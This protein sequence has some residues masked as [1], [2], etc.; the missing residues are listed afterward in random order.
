MF[1]ELSGPGADGIGLAFTDRLGGV[2]TGQFASFNLGHT[3]EDALGDLRTN[4][5]ALRERLGTG[6]VSAV[7]QVH[8]HT[9]KAVEGDAAHSLG[10]DSWLGDR[11]EGVEPLSHADAQVTGLAGIP[12]AVRVADCVPVLLADGAAGIIGAAHAGRV[13]LLGGVLQATVGAMRARGASHLQAWIGPHICGHC[14][15]VPGSMQR[16]ACAQIP[17][18]RCRT[19]WGTPSLDLGAGAQQVLE[20]DGVEVHR[21]DPCTRTD[22]RFFSH[23]GDHGRTGNQIGLIW[24]A[25]GH[26]GPVAGG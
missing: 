5:A 20:E 12:L 18:L 6:P 16:Q 3:D 24:R 15:E 13:G 26:V 4:M 7:R 25:A 17:A 19:S 2:S 11:V 10:D 21:V 1:A 22:E 23:R 14:Y 9:V 8:G